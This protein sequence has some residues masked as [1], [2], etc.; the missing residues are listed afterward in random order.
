LASGA[1]R[2]SLREYPLD[3]LFGFGEPVGPWAPADCRPSITYGGADEVV[4]LLDTATERLAGD[5]ELTEF[6]RVLIE[7]RELNR[8]A[9]RA[10]A[11]HRS[12]EAYEVAR[13]HAL[14]HAGACCLHTW[15]E[16]GDAFGGLIADRAWLL[17]ALRRVLERLG[18][19]TDPDHRAEDRLV[20]RLEELDD[21]DS[22]F[23]LVPLRLAAQ[24]R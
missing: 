8:E 3:V 5:A 20:R 4:D 23:S 16:R 12:P 2:P 10:T 13:R 18:R 1:R 14:V 19:P 11:A 24:Y 15:L 6:A 7:V 17:V 22:A 21:D 9:V